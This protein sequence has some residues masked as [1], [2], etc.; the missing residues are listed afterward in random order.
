ME[1]SYGMHACI[2]Y[3]VPK[4]SFF[5]IWRMEEGD[6]STKNL[7]YI[8]PKYICF[9]SSSQ[10]YIVEQLIIGEYHVLKRIIYV[11]EKLKMSKFNSCFG[12]T[13]YIIVEVK[14]LFVSTLINQCKSKSFYR[15]KHYKPRSI[16]NANFF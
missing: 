6:W 13:T 5:V 15:T 2:F 8:V 10:V 14:E 3:I 1:E 4:L 12:R 9:R 16:C 7:I 11:T